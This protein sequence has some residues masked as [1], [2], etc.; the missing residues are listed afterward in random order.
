M[1][2]ECRGKK[3]ERI[4]LCEGVYQR[5]YKLHIQFPSHLCWVAFWEPCLETSKQYLCTDR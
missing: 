2:V 1:Q 5:L 3:G 4:G